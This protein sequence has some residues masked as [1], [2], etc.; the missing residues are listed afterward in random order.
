LY[1]TVVGRFD[2]YRALYYG[3]QFKGGVR[4]V[5][6][7]RRTAI[8]LYRFLFIMQVFGLCVGLLQLMSELRSG[9]HFYLIG[10][11]IG[12]PIGVGMTVLWFRQW[13]AI[14]AVSD[15]QWNRAW[16][17]QPSGKS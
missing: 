14:E 17:I 3:R 1:S 5:A 7:K 15:E 12:G 9:V 6:M 16:F 8:R 4:F 10:Y 2:F 13:K 11:L